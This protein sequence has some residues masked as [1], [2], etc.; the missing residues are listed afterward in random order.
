MFNDDS[1]ITRTIR[2]RGSHVGED[3]EMQIC[4]E[5]VGRAIAHDISLDIAETNAAIEETQDTPAKYRP[6]L[7]RILA[8]VILRERQ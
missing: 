2:I 8:N 3:V 7:V 5:D 6:L 1:Q 4:T